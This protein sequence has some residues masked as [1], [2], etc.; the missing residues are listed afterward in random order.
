M[1]VQDALN[2]LQQNIVT[3]HCKKKL[4]SIIA[5]LHELKMNFKTNVRTTNICVFY[6]STWRFEHCI[7]KNKV[8]WKEHGKGIL[9][10]LWSFKFLV[11]DMPLHSLVFLYLLHVYI[12]PPVS[13]FLDV[14]LEGI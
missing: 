5:C 14:P 3:K 13:E 8:Q 9:E 2:R 6:F 7:V 1:I 10:N 11:G 12:Q 4:Q